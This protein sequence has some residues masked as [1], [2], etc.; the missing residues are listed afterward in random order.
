MPSAALARLGTTRSVYGGGVL[1]GKLPNLGSAYGWVNVLKEGEIE[2]L[3][4]L[5]I[6]QLTVLI[7]LLTAC[8]PQ[9][10]QF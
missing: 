9:R 1:V 3:L 10:A 2:S 8:H 5:W 6:L 7:L 4:S